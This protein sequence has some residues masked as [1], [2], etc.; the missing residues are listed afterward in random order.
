MISSS[1]SAIISIIGFPKAIIEFIDLGFSFLNFVDGHNLKDLVK[2]LRWAKTVEKPAIVQILTKKG[3]GYICSEKDPELY[4]GV[5]SLDFRVWVSKKRNNLDFSTVFGKQILDFAKKDERICAITAAMGRATGLFEFEKNF[6][7]RYFDV[8]IAEEHAVT[9]AAGLAKSGMFPVFAI[10]SSF[11]QRAYDQ[12]VHDVS[13]L[14]LHVVLAVDRAGISEDGP[15]H[16]GVFDVAFLTTI[17]N[18]KIYS[19]TTYKELKI[20]LET[21]IYKEKGLVALR[22]PKSSEMEGIIGDENDFFLSVGEGEIV[23][24]SYGILFREVMFLKESLNRKGIKVFCVKMKKIFPI[25]EQLIEKLKRYKE[26]FFFEEGIKSGGIG[27]HISLKLFQ[28][29]FTGMFN[30]KAIDGKFIKHMSYREA[31]I[32]IGLDS[33]GMEREV[34]EKSLILKKVKNSF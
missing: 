9:F 11:L 28:N 33:G 20:M 12:L 19:P 15:T 32:E 14:D 31:L 4:H 21:A 23:L 13:I 26:I 5:G 6:K 3:K 22:Y 16:H 25:E 29:G 30:L 17:P 1:T 10:Y 7:D 8:G 24:I 18:I 2:A 34:L 27:E